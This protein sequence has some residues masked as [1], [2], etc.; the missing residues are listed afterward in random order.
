[1]R[2][3]RFLFGLVLAT[4][5]CVATLNAQALNAKDEG[6]I[7][8]VLAQ[9][10]A[11]WNHHDMK[12]LAGL[13]TDDAEWIN[14]VG[15]HWRGKADI[16]KAHDVYH[17]TL[18]TKTGIHFTKIEIRAIAPDVAVAVVT[19]DFDASL[20]PDGSTRPVSQ[21]RFTLVLVKRGGNWK[22][23]HG[24][25]TI[26]NADAQPFDPVYSGWNGEVQKK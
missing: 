4:S 21:D 16:Y 5:Y 11:D 2:P 10:E 1:M 3:M 24:H 23:A 13:F 7:G 20:L 6:A 22:I 26:I 17:R 25:N 14:V 15:M 12:A 18:F 8:D 9:Y 19:E